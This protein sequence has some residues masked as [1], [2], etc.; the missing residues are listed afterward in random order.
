VEAYV[1]SSIKTWGIDVCIEV[2]RKSSIYDKFSVSLLSN[3]QVVVYMVP[4]LI[5][6]LVYFGVNGCRRRFVLFTVSL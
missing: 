2:H 3:L 4:G 5:S 1:N 6:I